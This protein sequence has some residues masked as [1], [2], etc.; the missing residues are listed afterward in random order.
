MSEM[1]RIRVAGECTLPRF[2]ASEDEATAAYK[3]LH[4]DHAQRSGEYTLQTVQPIHMADLLPDLRSEAYER[5]AVFG[6]DNS[7]IDSVDAE[8]WDLYREALQLTAD[9]F[10]RETGFNLDQVR[11]VSSVVVRLK[12]LG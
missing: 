9:A 6:A 8:W 3:T 11:V 2:Y 4:E 12:G 7:V 1:F 10:E 5:L